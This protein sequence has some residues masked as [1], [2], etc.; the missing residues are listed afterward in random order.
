MTGTRS[1]EGIGHETFFDMHEVKKEGEEFD[2]VKN[3]HDMSNDFN[4]FNNLSGK[5]NIQITIHIVQ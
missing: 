3:K 4:N 5:H 1:V 2:F